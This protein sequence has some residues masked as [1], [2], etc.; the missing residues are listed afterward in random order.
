MDAVR[1]AVGS[2]GLKKSRPHR[3]PGRHTRKSHRVRRPE[4]P[5]QVPVEVCDSPSIDAQA[6]PDRVA[7]LY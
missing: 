3:F 7:A 2:Q 5:V 1:H 6:L 4:Q